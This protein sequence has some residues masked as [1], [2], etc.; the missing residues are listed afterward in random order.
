MRLCKKENCSEP[1]IKRGKYCEAHCTVR[2][3]RDS[4]RNTSEVLEERKVSEPSSLERERLQRSIREQRIQELLRTQL[5]EEDERRKRELSE[6]YLEERLFREEQQREYEETVRLDRERLRL[7]KEA[8][9]KIINEKRD[10]EN[11]L[12]E[13]RRKVQEDEMS[14]EEKYFKIKFVFPNV[15]GLSIIQC[16]TK[17][18]LFSNIFDFL[19]VF[20]T[21]SGINFDGYD[22]L[23]YPNLSFEKET[24][25]DKRFSDYVSSK[26]V[27]F[28]VKEKEKE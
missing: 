9:D 27:Q 11:E 21:D 25:M 7:Q 24:H 17:N 13:K 18:C 12:N 8:Q 16:F 14:E 5:R 20:M 22:I 19:D 1:S 26:N 2:R 10:K 23:S 3:I 28:T 6:K 15:H 4:H